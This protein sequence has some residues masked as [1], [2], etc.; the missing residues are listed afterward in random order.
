MNNKIIFEELLKA[1]KIKVRESNLFNVPVEIKTAVNFD[2]IEGMLLGV[3]IGDSLGFPTENMQPHERL[4]AHGEVIDYLPIGDE[5]RGVPSDETQFTMWTLEQ[6]IKDGYFDAEAAA[7]SFLNK[8]ILGMSKTIKEFLTNFHKHGKKWHEAGSGSANSCSMMRIAPVILP[9]LKNNNGNL[10]IDAALCSMMTNNDSAAIASCMAL[11][12][13]IL[14]AMDMEKAPEPMFWLD[15]FIE[16]LKEF[17]TNFFY[18][19]RCAAYRDYQGPLSGY[20]DKAVRE[21][22]NEN[23]TVLEACAKWQSGSYLLETVPCVIYILMKHA[24]SFENA[25]IR[26]V[27]DTADNDTIAAIVGSVLGA[28]HGKSAIPK[29]W[30][31]NLSGRTGVSD[32]GRIFEI[33]S[34][35]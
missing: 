8:K 34:S 6:I 35:A 16:T 24:D 5:T 2:K 12:N 32:D 14:A 11:I 1:G 18:K 33:I 22:Y 15:K 9:H 10:W 13:L 30:L 20:L 28:L 23:L 27:N 25:L 31:D 19:P 29:R 7:G 26:A 3:A 21:A 17:E 4:K